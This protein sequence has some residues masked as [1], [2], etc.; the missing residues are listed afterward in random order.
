MID[1]E[2]N[3]TQLYNYVAEA[4]F[5]ISEVGRILSGW[6]NTHVARYEDGVLV[7]GASPVVKP[8]G[9]FV[10]LV[11]GTFSL[12]ERRLV[13]LA[14][15]GLEME[16]IFSLVI[17]E[18]WLL[19]AVINFIDAIPGDPADPVEGWMVD[20]SGSILLEFVSN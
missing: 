20:P 7:E 18:E 11:I 14:N 1:L 13:F 8:F 9:E 6:D 4:N 16:S 2:G 19:N 10:N 17:P 12:G 3:K 5:Y 15:S